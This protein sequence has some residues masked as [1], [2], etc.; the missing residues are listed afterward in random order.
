[1]K[2]HATKTIG[3]AMIVPTPQRP[4][5]NS[6]LTPRSPDGALA[7][8]GNSP[9]SIAGTPR[10][11]ATLDSALLQPGYGGRIRER[12]ARSQARGNHPANVM[13]ERIAEGVGAGSRL[14]SGERVCKG[15][16]S[17]RRVRFADHSRRGRTY[18][19]DRRDVDRGRSSALRVRFADHLRGCRTY[20]RD[21]RTVD[22]GRSSGAAISPRGASARRRT[23][24][25]TPTRP[26]DVS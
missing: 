26:F 23:Q 10:Y 17:L 22:R 6:R 3:W 14:P 13:A 11:G 12:P 15:E 4:F 7:K 8:S 5:K 1:M 16:P 19:H 25:C 20:N 2:V 18:D 21:R 24:A 9:A